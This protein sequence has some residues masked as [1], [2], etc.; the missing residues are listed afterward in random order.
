LPDN[1]ILF[2]LCAYVMGYLAAIPIGATQIEIAKRFINGYIFS[3]MMIIAG[4]VISDFTYGVIALF[5]I[6]PFLQD[7]DIVAIFAF[8]NSAILVVLGIMTLRQSR[9]QVKNRLDTTG[10]LRKKHMSFI[11][12]YL[13]AITNPLMIYWWLLGSRFLSN[14]FNIERY[15]TLTIF[16]LLISGTLGIGSYPLSMLYGIHKT[17]RFFSEAGIRKTTFIFGLALFG[18]AAYFIYQGLS[19]FVK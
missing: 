11:T 12:G 7:P 15:N 4:A 3:A 9:K 10:V 16:I 5:G 18:L 8:V 14:V 2:A 6:A 19:Y 17:K 1:V 13:L